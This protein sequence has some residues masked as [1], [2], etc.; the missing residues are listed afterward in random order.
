[1]TQDGQT[2]Q[3]RGLGKALLLGAG[4]AVAAVG[5]YAAYK[6]TTKKKKRVKTKKGKTREIDCDVLV[7]DSGNELP[8]QEFNEK[9][10]CIN[11]DA[12]LEKASKEGKFS[13]NQQQQPAYGGASQNN[14]APYMQQ[15][16]TSS[17][18]PQGN[19]GNSKPAY[20]QGL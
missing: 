11:E 5:A 19:S 2:D 12:V 17:G 18:Y 9:G 13:A 16:A 7:D 3:D 1:M 8:G 15:Q 20:M 4:A 6:K 14:Q 10:R